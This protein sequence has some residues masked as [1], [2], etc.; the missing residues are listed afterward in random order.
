LSLQDLQK[1][2]MAID[3]ELPVL[4]YLLMGLARKMKTWLWPLEEDED[5]RLARR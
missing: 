1:F 5:W 4:E 2:V 3:D